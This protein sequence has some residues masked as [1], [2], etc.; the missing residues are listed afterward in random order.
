MAVPKNK[1]SQARRDK[2][3]SNVW[4]LDA[5]ALSICP[6]CGEYMAPH[7]VCSSCGVY[8]GRQVIAKED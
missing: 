7:K 1:H 4:K 8:N 2:R 6:N 5:P 3:R